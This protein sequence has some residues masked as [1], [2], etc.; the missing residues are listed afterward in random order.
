MPRQAKNHSQPLKNVRIPRTQIQAMRLVVDLVKSGYFFYRTGWIR[1]Q[2][3]EDFALEMHN[4][5]GV[6]LTNKQREYRRSKKLSVGHL[7]VVRP[8]DDSNMKPTDRVFFCVLWSEGTGN[9]TVFPQYFDA[10]NPHQRLVWETKL[11]E[12]SPGKIEAQ[13]PYVLTQCDVP[14]GLARRRGGDIVLDSAGEQ[15]INSHRRT[16]TWLMTS[17]TYRREIDAA[18]TRANRLYSSSPRES[19]NTPAGK[20][21]AAIKKYAEEIQTWADFLY[22]R[23]G[24]HGVNKQRFTLYRAIEK[25][26]YKS[27]ILDY[28]AKNHDLKITTEQMLASLRRPSPTNPHCALGWSALSLGEWLSSL[29]N[30]TD[31]TLSF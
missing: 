25:T 20:R 14:G 5:V 23:P 22:R 2:K 7:I 15:V 9:E 11:V 10:R 12:K 4:K 19:D 30:A 26:I 24:F 6:G 27:G 17:D 28:A 29:E 3:L 8:F 16:L 18:K 31:N 1:I 21:A 13:R